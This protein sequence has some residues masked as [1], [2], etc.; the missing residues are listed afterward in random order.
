MTDGLTNL[1]NRKAFDEACACKK[2]GES[3]AVVLRKAESMLEQR[4]GDMIV[5]AEKAEELSRP[6]AVQARKAAMGRS[7]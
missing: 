4:K 6:K 2:Q 5:T 3:W 7:D 1:A